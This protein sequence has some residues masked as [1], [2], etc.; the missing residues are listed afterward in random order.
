MHCSTILFYYIMLSPFL[1]DFWGWIFK[2]FSRFVQLSCIV[3]GSYSSAL[4]YYFKHRKIYG[5]YSW[6]SLYNV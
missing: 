4:I 6:P 2:C 3:V 5:M 1:D